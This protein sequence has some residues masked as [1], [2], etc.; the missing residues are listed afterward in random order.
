M[1]N[2]HGGKTVAVTV[3]YGSQSETEN[4]DRNDSV[5]TVFDWA[6]DKFAIDPTKAADYELALAGAEDALP[7]DTKIGKLAKGASTLNL[8]LL[9]GDLVN[10]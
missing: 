7:S 9:A 10:G 1:A 3:H 4:F 2:E 5:E 8:D 6:V